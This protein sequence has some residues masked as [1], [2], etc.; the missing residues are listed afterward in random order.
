M[1]KRIIATKGLNKQRDWENYMM[2]TF[3]KYYGDKI[4]DD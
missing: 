1:L 2:G 3:T 4:Q